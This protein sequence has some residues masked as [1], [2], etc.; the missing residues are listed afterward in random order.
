MYLPLLDSALHGPIFFALF[1]ADPSIDDLARSLKLKD[2][3]PREKSYCYCS[4]FIR[5]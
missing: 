4:H 1:M 3:A 2:K 5:H